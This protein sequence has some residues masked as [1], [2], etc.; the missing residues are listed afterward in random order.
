TR[1]QNRVAIEFDDLASSSDALH[2][3]PRLAVQTLAFGDAFTAGRLFTR[4][5]ECADLELLPGGAHAAR[6]R[7]LRQRGLVLAAFL[8]EI[9]PEDSGAEYGEDEAGADGAPDIAHRI[10]DGNLVQH[11]LGIVDPR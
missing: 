8:R 10:S 5:R 6:R 9:D 4:H 3:H 11:R 1:L 7:S 2:V